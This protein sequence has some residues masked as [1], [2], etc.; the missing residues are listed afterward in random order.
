MTQ[1]HL[2]LRKCEPRHWW[3]ARL[4]EGDVG[5]NEVRNESRS[6]EEGVSRDSET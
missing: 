5:I 1:P 2:C 6:N 3:E 4:I